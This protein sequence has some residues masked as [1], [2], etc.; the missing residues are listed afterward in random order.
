MAAAPLIRRASLH[1]HAAPRTLMPSPFP[2]TPPFFPMAATTA[3]LLACAWHAGASEP[4]SADAAAA[5]A[6]RSTGSIRDFPTA[7][8]LP[9]HRRLVAA[10]ASL[11]DAAS[12]FA[13]GDDGRLVELRGAW[14]DAA[15]AWAG[16]CAFTFGPVHSLGHAVALD[17]PID[18]AGLERL[19]ELHD[20]REGGGG[21]VIRADAR[22]A[23]DE[24]ADTTPLASLGGLGAM[25]HLLHGADGE[26]RP[27]TFTA[28]ER[29]RLAALAAG[30]DRAANE[31]LGAWLDGHEGH[32][33]FAK[34]LATAGEPDNHAYLSSEAGEAEI[35]RGLTG[36]LDVMVHEELPALH[37]E[38]EAVPTSASTIRSLVLLDAALDGARA[39][40]NAVPSAG[41]STPPDADATDADVGRALADASDALAAAIRAAREARPFQAEIEQVGASA[42][43]ALTRLEQLLP[44]PSATAAERIASAGAATSHNRTSSAYEE[45]P[46]NLTPRGAEDH[47]LGD[48][49]FEEAFV[50]TAEHDNAGLG[51]T[52]NNTACGGCH[53]RNGRGMPVPGQLLLRVSDA[54]PGGERAAD[55]ESETLV[56]NRAPPVA[57]LGNQIQDFAVVGAAPEARVEIDWVET[58][59]RYADGTP[60]RLRSPSFEVTLAESGAPLPDSVRVS[61]RVPPHVYGLGLLEA[62]PEEDILALA[63]PLDSDGDGISGRPNRVWD[64]RAQ[65]TSL[66]RF[67]WKAN[68]PNLLQQTADAYLNDM[69][70]HSPLFP[71]EDGSVEIDEET[72]RVATAYSQTLAVPARAAVDDP[73]VRQGEALFAE[74][75][76]VACHVDSF[77]TGSHEYPSLENQPIRP[78]TDLLLHDM[79][80]GLAD[81]RDDYDADGREWR[82]PALWGIGVA[83]TVLPYS[84]FLHDGRARTLEEAILWHGGEGERSKLAFETMAAREREAM[85]RFLS[86]L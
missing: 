58:S 17:S 80:E 59:G 8:V 81:G 74:A 48:E 22:L 5:A 41:A 56:L 82:T 33:P 12:A 71:A 35:V 25:S 29:A 76:C 39:T 55:E 10:A 73:L 78:Y 3:L 53:I 20:E 9:A 31:L 62:I 84:G 50:Q 64:E 67:G 77:T 68:S 2:I 44:S 60:Y 61:P 1:P 72:L 42:G 49:A 83:Q 28:A 27:V 23:T 11:H 57:G 4:E 15:A 52:F 38:S 34:R 75:G 66:G 26:R 85:V 21:A 40:W 51:P 63:D 16:E 24:I 37:G 46:P 45:A 70:I 54:A 36:C 14:R 43:A 13:A 86:S 30:V 19:L 18:V 69:G 65:G 7:V 32:P 47:E 79:G 6:E